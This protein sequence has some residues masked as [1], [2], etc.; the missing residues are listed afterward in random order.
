MKYDI[1]T[2]GDAL[3][4]V[5][6]EPEL[7]VKT[8]QSVLSGKSMSLEFGE[9]IP[10]NWVDF[11]I[12]GSACNAAVGFGRL[13]FKTGIISM[14][15]DDDPK[16]KV[17]KRLKN[18]DVDTSN[19]IINKNYQTGYSVILSVKGERTILVFHGPKDYQKVKIDPNLAT[20]WLYLAP[21]G[22]DTDELEKDIVSFVAEK[23]ARIGWNPGSI[24]IAQGANHWK[25]VLKCTSVLFLN[26][27]ESIKF[28]GI[29]VRPEMKEVMKR[30]YNY[31]PKIVVVT[32]GK[33]GA[34]AY[35]G[36]DFYHLAPDQ[37][38]EKVDVTGAGD[39]FAI[40]FLGR[41]IKA[42]WK[43]EISESE[44]REALAWGIKNSSSVIKYIGAQRGLLT[45]S[46]MMK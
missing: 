4:D 19:V 20:G 35:N 5:F 30:L 45:K 6:V 24:Q 17:L 18:E 9:K 22:H 27:E 44:I 26:K 29:P 38:I 13:G 31:G 1:V 16:D 15:G 12:G 11:E 33:E 25:H 14:F 36:K 28:L 2:I 21:L 46:E 42:D 10:L 23:D 3:E 8:D 39:S 43:E 34:T 40:G 41:L 32:N 7:K 37:R